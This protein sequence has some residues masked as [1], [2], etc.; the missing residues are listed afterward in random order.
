MSFSP[1][2][3]FSS[4]PFCNIFINSLRIS[5]SV[6]SQL[7]PASPLYQLFTFSSLPVPSKS[8]ITFFFLFFCQ[9]VQ[10]CSATLR[11][12]LLWCE[13]TLEGVTPLKKTVPPS[14]RSFRMSKA[15]QIVLRLSVFFPCST[16][17]CCL[18]AGCEHLEHVIPI[19]MCL[20]NTVSFMLSVNC[21]SHN[22][23]TLFYSKTFKPCV[24]K[25]DMNIWLRVEIHSFLFSVDWPV[26]GLWWSQKVIS[27]SHYSHATI[28]PVGLS[29][30]AVILVAYKTHR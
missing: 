30:Q 27:F 4:F 1:S 17:E 19:L 13:V 28:A 23:S 11:M 12:V 21:G 22:I 5:Y 7:P 14:L 6:F 20:V 3:P 24:E 8:N 9:Q 18:V 26:W 2:L 15:F 10:F 16:L 25:Y 29:C